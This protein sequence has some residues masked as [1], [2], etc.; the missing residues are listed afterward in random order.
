MKP[1]SSFVEN[2]N[3]LTDRIM[4]DNNLDIIKHRRDNAMKVVVVVSVAILFVV[5]LVTI[6][7]YVLI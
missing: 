6:L 3:C 2:N 4:Q 5:V 7:S 1:T